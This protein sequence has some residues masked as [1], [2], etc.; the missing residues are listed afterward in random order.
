[1]FGSRGNA[2]NNRLKSVQQLDG[3]RGARVQHVRFA[4]T[5][6]AFVLKFATVSRD[7]MVEV[8][9]M[10]FWHDLVLF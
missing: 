10:V 3:W 1:M 8:P 2:A 9:G 5:Q 6:R 7:R 4:S